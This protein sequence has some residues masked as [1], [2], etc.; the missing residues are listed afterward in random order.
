MRYL[1]GGLAIILAAALARL[2]LYAGAEDA[3]YLTGVS[4]WEHAGRWGKT[5][6]VVA[7]MAITGATVIGLLMSTFS[8]GARLRR[9]TLPAAALSC[10]MLLT[11]WFFLT[12]GH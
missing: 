11:A 5:P 10:V 3:Y 7:A 6:I 2:V 1:T 12:A 8:P 9:L 4:R